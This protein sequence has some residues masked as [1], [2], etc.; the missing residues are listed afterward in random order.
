[1]GFIY[2]LKH[3][4]NDVLYVMKIVIVS[5]SVETASSVFRKMPFIS[6]F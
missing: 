2:Y 3:T 5:P 4:E 1:M 6:L